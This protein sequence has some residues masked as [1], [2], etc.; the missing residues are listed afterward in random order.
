M[1]KT[2]PELRDYS[3][4]EVI[5]LRA[6]AGAGAQSQGRRVPC[7]GEIAAALPFSPPPL[8]GRRRS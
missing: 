6:I 1:G 7:S 5:T 4:D 8:L 3:K 2:I